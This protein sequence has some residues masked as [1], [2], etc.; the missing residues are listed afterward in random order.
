MWMSPLT[1]YLRD[2]RLLEDLV[3]AKKLIKD[4]A[5][6]IITGGELY[7]R[8]FSFPLLWCVKGE[9]ARYVIKEVHEGVYS[10]H[11]GG[12]ALANKIA[13]V[14][15]YWPTLKGDCAEYVK[16][17]DKCQRFVE[18]TSRSTASF[19]AQLKIKQRFTSV[20][21]PQTNGQVEAANTVILRG[22]RRRLEEA[23]EKW[24]E[25]FPQVLWSYHTTPHSSTNETP[26]RLTFS[27]EAVIPVEIREPS[28]QTA[29]FQPAENENEMRVNMDLL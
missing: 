12:R 3:E 6:Y 19:C 27:K 11:I 2:E 24:A 15:Y 28:P 14:R 18:F 1:A 25:E 4:M 29:L 13:R 26:F 16:K 8:G 10:S 20:E 9:E 7:R 22:L 23:K 17:C 21:H 5:K